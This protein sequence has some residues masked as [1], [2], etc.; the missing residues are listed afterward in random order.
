MTKILTTLL[1]LFLLVYLF[2]CSTEQEKILPNGKVLKIGVI[3]PMSGPDKVLGQDCLEGIQTVVG[4]HPLLNNGDTLELLVEDDKND[5]ELAVKAY[6]KLVETDKV[7]AVI[8]ASSSTVALAINSL[9]DQHKTPTVILLASHPDIS[10]GTKYISQITFDNNFQAQV[11]ALFVR[12]ELLLEHVAVFMD[13]D[14]YHSSSLATEFTRKF[15]SIEGQVSD[16][17]HISAEKVDYGEI[18]SHLRDND[19]Q[20][21]YLPVA[22]EHVIEISKK[23]VEINWTPMA[24]GGDGL[25]TRA[26]AQKPDEA[27]YLEGFYA[28]DLYSS[29]VEMS[30]HGEK[31]SKA[32]RRKFKSRGSTFPAIGIEGMAILRHAINRCNDS[33]DK[34]CINVKLHDTV[35]FLGV[36]GRI[37]IQPSGKAL[38]PLAVNRIRNGRLEFIVKVY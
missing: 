16:V 21:L 17:I 34:E 11:A 18:L 27:Q 24:M 12:D 8:V 36:M 6:I 7:A 22:A 38:R 28:T 14:S 23:M 33:S 13:M 1:T 9:A 37:T 20:L 4:L 29:D 31:V 15:S 25:L 30:V 10:K 19:V 32:L 3:G 26:L 5:Q 35:D 2:S